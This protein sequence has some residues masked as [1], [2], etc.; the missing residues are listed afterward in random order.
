MVTIMDFNK[1]DVIARGSP[2]R[3]TAFPDAS[4]KV[5]NGLPLSWGN[6]TIN[7][8]AWPPQYAGIP[9]YCSGSVWAGS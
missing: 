4:S 7:K 8:A 2:V 9:R 6:F 5:R 1:N 3:G